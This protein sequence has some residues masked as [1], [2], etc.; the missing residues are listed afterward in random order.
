M[1]KKM[2]LVNCG[3]RSLCSIMAVV[4]MTIVTTGVISIMIPGKALAQ[5]TDAA[6]QTGRLMT[7]QQKL[8]AKEQPDDSAQTAFSYEAGD[9]VFVTGE[10]EDGWYTV[11][12]Q[13]KT[14]YINANSYQEAFMAADVDVEALDAELEAEEEESRQIIEETE[15]YRVES[16]RSRIWGA[17][18]IVLVVGIF[19]T[20]I[21]ST[22]RAEKEKNVKARDRDAEGTILDLDKE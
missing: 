3:I 15:R 8:D 2:D 6:G 10:T 22:V 9:N 5:E 7:A 20:G 18:I 11:F 1:K 17:G 14:G 16:R 12:Y 13:G 19:A 21:I 4:V